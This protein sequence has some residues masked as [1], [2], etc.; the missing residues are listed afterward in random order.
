MCSAG[1]LQPKKK[2]ADDINNKLCTWS[3]TNMTIMTIV[4]I[5]SS[6]NNLLKL[7]Y[8]KIP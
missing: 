6:G 5:I 8:T 4:N 3:L 1:T 7:V 2:T